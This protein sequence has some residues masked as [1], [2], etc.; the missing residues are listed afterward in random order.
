[1]TITR[2]TVRQRLLSVA[3]VL[4]TIATILVVA[5]APANAAAVQ[6]TSGDYY[7]LR[8]G[9]YDNPTL[10]LD[11]VNATTGPG[12][13]FQLWDCGTQ[14]NQQ[15]KFERFTPGGVVSWRLRPRYDPNEC[16]AVAGAS[17]QPNGWLT[18]APCSSGWEQLFVLQP[19]AGSTIFKLVPRYETA[20]NMC[21]ESGL[22]WYSGHGQGVFQEPC[23]G[24]FSFPWEIWNSPPPVNA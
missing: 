11:V 2:R 13:A 20:T 4:A 3:A 12:G 10:C 5:E 7:Y 18:T 8:S 17:S 19:F 23:N 9:A 16:V 15:F 24:G 22:P 6:P 1:M 21:V 14:W